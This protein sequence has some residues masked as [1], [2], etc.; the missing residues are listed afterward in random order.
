MARHVLVPIDGSDPAWDALEHA[1][2][3][4]SGER[5]TVLHVADPTAGMH[6]GFESGYFDQ[7]LFEQA[8][9][10]GKSLCERARERLE[11]REATSGTVLETAVETGRPARTIVRYA[12]DHDVDHVVIGSHGR[13]GV[14][15]V[16]LGSVAESVV[17]RAGVPVTVV[18]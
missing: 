16:L 4:Y 3:R 17:R 9:D 10:R 1:L 8:L 11:E 7:E 2:E 13:T 6:T 5:I 12:A 18:R 14:S 15:R